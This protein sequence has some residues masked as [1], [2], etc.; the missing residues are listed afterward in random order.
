MWS[1]Y[2]I[3]AINQ[4]SE[5][6]QNSREVPER[7]IFSGSLSETWPGFSMDYWTQGASKM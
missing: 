1:K 4:Y 3:P 6:L 7:G 2:G 5:S